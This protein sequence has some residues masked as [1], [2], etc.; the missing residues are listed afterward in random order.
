MTLSMDLAQIQ[1]LMLISVRLIGFLVI[2]PPFSHRSFPGTIKAMLGIG[3][4][5]AVLPKVGA[6]TVEY[7]TGEYML[8]LLLQA[9][10]GVALGF[11]VYLVFAAVQSAGG[12]IDLTGGFSMAAS[13]DPM[14]NSNGAQ[15]NRLFQM[16]TLALLFASD[17]H[18]VVLGGLFRSFE[19]LPPGQAVDVGQLGEV[20]TSGMTSLFLSAVQI[21]G[22][23]MIILILS[24]MGLGL[25]TRVA[26]ALNVF[27]LG[28]PLKIYL[29]LSLVSLIYLTLPRVIETLT[30]RSLSS[31]WEV[32]R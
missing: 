23:L 4:A 27:V 29:T 13:F 11:V 8:E 18:Q 12:L 14:N 9:F 19:F 21:A 7:S 28:F 6:S 3:L 1:T 24:D 16:T 32:V 15:F 2:A 31:M 10:I 25:L 5:I 17:A 22:P 20:L 26:P 30:S